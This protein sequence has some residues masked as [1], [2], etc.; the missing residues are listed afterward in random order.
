MRYFLVVCFLNTSCLLLINFIH[1]QLFGVP[2]PLHLLDVQ[3][4]LDFFG[5]LT[6]LCTFIMTQYIGY[7]KTKP[8][9]VHSSGWLAATVTKL[10][11]LGMSSVNSFLK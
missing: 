2:L 7:L 1:V 8:V 3:T 5:L 9:R 4:D 6:L 11:K 10:L